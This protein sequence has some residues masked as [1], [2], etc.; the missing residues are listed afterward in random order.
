MQLRI[1]IVTAAKTAVELVQDLFAAFGRG[2]VPYILERVTPDCEWV[3]HGE[4]L[5][6]AG[7]FRGPAGV[8]Q[9]FS[10][11][12]AN[13]QILTF[14]P[15]EFFSEGNTVVVLGSESCNVI[16]TRKPAQTNW[17]MVFRLRDGKVY[18]WESHF[19]TLAYY[20]AYQK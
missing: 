5:P 14:E 4:G 11:L 8:G 2:D 16:A 17:S 15:R 10:N 13:E 20:R 12:V 3:G 6:Y 7:V 1:N 19:D 9:F 18:Y